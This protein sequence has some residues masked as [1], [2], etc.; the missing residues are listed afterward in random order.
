[1]MKQIRIHKYFKYLVFA[2]ILFSIGIIQSCVDD[3]DPVDGVEPQ[4]AKVGEVITINLLVK[5]KSE[6]LGDFD[7][8]NLYIGFLVPRSW[9]ATQGNNTTITYTSDLGN[10][11]FVLLSDD[12]KVPNSEYP[13]LSYPDYLK[14]VYRAGNNFLDDHEWVVYKTDKQYVIR[15]GAS[16]NPIIT[17]KTKVGQQNMFT[18]LAYY[19]SYNGAGSGQG[20]NDNKV[21]L[22]T[23]CLEVTGGANE[24]PIDFCNKPLANASPLAASDNDFLTFDFDNDLLPTG[25]AGTTDIYLCAQA[26]TADNKVITRC[27]GVPANQLKPLPN[28]EY[29][30]VIYPR[31]F[32]GLQKDE[33]LTRITYKIANKDGSVK[34]G[35]RGTDE[36]FVYRFT[37]CN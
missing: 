18:K 37:S 36:A 19:V 14:A 27:G 30:L 31:T 22:S 32:F 12:V 25:L 8:S 2:V 17:I 11:R 1:M 26:T 15:Q 28:D 29:R 33:T 23:K 13:D 20:S 10:G 24:E 6:A 9:R 7:P 5:I 3:I 21:F 34:V 35:K 4:T 16:V